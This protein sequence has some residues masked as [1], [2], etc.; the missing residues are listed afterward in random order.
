MVFC[1]PKTSLGSSVF[2]ILFQGLL[3]AEDIFKVS[4]GHRISRSSMG[5]RPFQGHQ[6]AYEFSKF[7]QIE[8][9]IKVFCGPK[10]FS[11]IED[12]FTVFCASEIFSG[13]SVDCQLFYDL[14]CLEDLLKVF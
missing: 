5:L 1:G 9:V 13:S 12:L 6:W 2:R 11:R 3:L 4:C 8:D 14:L 10:A 7:M